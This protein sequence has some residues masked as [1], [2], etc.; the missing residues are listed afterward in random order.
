MVIDARGSTGGIA[1]LWNS[2]ELT[3]D[4]WINMQHILTGWFR[5][6]GNKDWY[7]LFA[8]YGPHILVEK[9]NFLQRIKILNLMHEDN[10]WLLAGDFNLIT[11]LEEKK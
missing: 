2:A 11:L 7:F 6:I 9:E 3:V 4:Y 1:I 10:L 8:V 5:L